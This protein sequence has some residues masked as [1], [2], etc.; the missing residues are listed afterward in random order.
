[1]KRSVMIGA[2]KGGV[3]KSTLS[4]NVAAMAAMKGLKVAVLDI[5]KQGTSKRWGDIRKTKADQPRVDV[6][7][8]VIKTLNQANL[9]DQAGALIATFKELCTDNDL[10]VVDAGGSDNP[11]MRFLIPEVDQ[12]YVPISPAAADGWGLETFIQAWGEAVARNVQNAKRPILFAN[13]IGFASEERKM[14]LEIL[15]DYPIML[16]GEA[17]V[18]NRIIFKHAMK[19]GQGVLEYKRSDPKARSE[20]LGVYRMI[21]GEAF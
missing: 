4:T 2:T 7:H 12:I 8:E 10:V 15:Q 9:L 16:E 5:D 18:G 19:A 3:G 20:M 21:T 13:R 11:A 14:L 17:K 1:M 6:R